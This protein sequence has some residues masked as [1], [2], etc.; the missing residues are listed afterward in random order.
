MTASKE[1]LLEQLAELVE[2]SILDEGSPAAFR[3]RA[4][5]NA[6]HELRSYHGELESL[7]V[8]QLTKLEGIGKSTAQK[9]RE[10]FETGTIAKLVKLRADYPPEYVRLSKIPGL[11]PKTLARLRSELG[12]QNVDDLRAA[13]EQEKLRDL[14]GLG[15]KTEKKLARAL[16]RLGGVGKDKR[17]PIADALPLARRLVDEL[18]AMEGV[19]R[20]EYCGSL[21]RFRETIGDI[22]IVVAAADAA[23]IMDWFVAMPGLREVLGHGDTKSSVV[24][25]SG[26]QV[27][28]RVV[29]AEQFGAAILY[30]TGSKAHNIRLRQRAIDRGWTLNE[31]GLTDAESGDVI[32][33]DTERAIYEAL[34]LA[35]VP[36]PMRED[37]G[38]IERAADD[39]LPTIVT[40]ADLRGDLHVHTDR[41]G[42]AHSPLA[43]IVARAA[44]LGYEYLVITD[45]GEDLPQNGVDRAGLEAQ[46][47]EIAELAD[48][49]ELAILQG[50]ELNIGPDGGLDYDAEFRAGFD[51]CIAGVHSDFDLPRESQTERL[52][53]AI[54]DPKVRAISHLS[55]RL[56]GRR[57]GIEFDVEAVL[58]AFVETDTALEINSGLA[59]LDASD[60][61]LLYAQ[62]LGVKFVITSDAHR[63][64]GLDR[65]QWGCLLAQ[66]G[67]VPREA[68][69]N[70]WPRK[71][72]LEWARAT[73]SIQ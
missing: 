37:R 58:K 59:R 10:Y 53:A 64:D 55:G 63:V 71:R 30:F 21:R 35:P 42:D 27:D 22:D 49:S 28:L 9:I 19:E 13:I 32:V 65:M 14:K 62:E 6:L 3:V 25:A 73:E 45:H 56:I 7:S 39:D 44:E 36:P 8:S 20:A 33:S 47:Q 4:Y 52:I 29:T 57:P 12:I 16:E 70:T 34:E 41:S 66:R 5:E 11:G 18:R 54:R 2:L 51:L 31:Y 50:V 67:F 1:G 38:E 48:G 43:A 60:S 46:R 61:V 40:P 26:I 68:V 69:V 24:T 72:F 17:T 15:E 23:P